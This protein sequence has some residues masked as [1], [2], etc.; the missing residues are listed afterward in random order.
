MAHSFVAYIDESGDDGLGGHYRRPGHRGGSSHWLGIGATMWRAS[1]DL[2]MVGCAQRILNR[3]QASKK[4]SG[5]HF[6]DLRHDQRV[7]AI[8]TLA[9]EPIRVSGVFAYKPIIREGIYTE[10]NQLYHYMTR[11]LLERLSWLCRD[12]RP[13]VPEGDGRLKLI[14]SRR[15]DMD[16]DDFQRYLRLL[17]GANDPAIQIH[18]PVID[19]DAVQARDHGSVYG[20]QLADLAV[21]GLRSAL[22]PDTFGNIEPRFAETLKPCIYR[23]GSN[24]LSYGAKLVP[25]HEAIEK[26]EPQGIIKPDLSEWLRLFR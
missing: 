12:L 18:W 17:K 7:M 1:R 14:F 20:L 9:N 13:N 16:Y 25:T 24:W 23:R 8:N 21:S 22:E 5:L 3:L 26:F 15:G 10:R 4:R 19:I 6:K 2:D 11:Y